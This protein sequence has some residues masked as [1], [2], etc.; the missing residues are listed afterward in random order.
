VLSADVVHEQKKNMVT[1][2]GQAPAVD[3]R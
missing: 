2:S 1:L 3:R